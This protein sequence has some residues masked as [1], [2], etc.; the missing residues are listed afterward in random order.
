LRCGVAFLDFVD[1]SITNIALPSI[2][3][4]LHFSVDG[5]Q[6][7]PSGYLLGSTFI[8]A[9]AV[10]GLRTTNTRGET[11]PAASDAEPDASLAAS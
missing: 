10:T 2:R 5:L 6:W 4:S 7:I 11:E 8:L 1:V 9:A 3:R